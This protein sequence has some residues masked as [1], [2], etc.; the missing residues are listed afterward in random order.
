MAKTTDYSNITFNDVLLPIRQILREQYNPN[1]VYISPF[2]QQQSEDFSIRIFSTRNEFI[3]IY[4]NTTF[5]RRIFVDVVHYHMLRN[6]QE[7]DYEYVYREMERTN[8]ILTNNHAK[9][10]GSDSNVTSWI[11][12]EVEEIEFENVTDDLIAVNFLFSCIISRQ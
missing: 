8:Q 11:E 2:F 12:G 1:P 3:S 7:Y 10:A 5:S 6:P 4:S 9:D